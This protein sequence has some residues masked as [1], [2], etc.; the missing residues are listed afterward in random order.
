[1]KL[2][3]VKHIGINAFML[4]QMGACKRAVDSFSRCFGRRIVRLTWANL[5]IYINVE[6]R[7]AS[8]DVRWF[9]KALGQNDVP[10]LWDVHEDAWLASCTRPWD[11]AQD[12]APQRWHATAAVIAYIADALALD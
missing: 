5:N 2:W 7:E 10:R 6:T 3:I 4:G 11:F 12:F 1:M 9:L 8:S